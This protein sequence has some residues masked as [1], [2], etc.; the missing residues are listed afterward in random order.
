MDAPLTMTSF[1]MP[2]LS[3]SCFCTSMKS[4]MLT[5]GKPLS[6]LSLR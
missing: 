2:R 4:R 6:F 5:M 3:T 1:L